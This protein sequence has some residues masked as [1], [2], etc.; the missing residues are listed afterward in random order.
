ME[1]GLPDHVMSEIEIWIRLNIDHRFAPR[2][3]S[4]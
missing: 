4:R 1:F 3:F 2:A